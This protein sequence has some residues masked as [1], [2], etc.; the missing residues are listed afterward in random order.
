QEVTAP[1]K[2]HSQWKD[3]LP[4][5][6][7]IRT[8]AGTPV[9]LAD[10]EKFLLSIFFPN[11]AILPAYS[12]YLMSTLISVYVFLFLFAG[13]IGLAIANSITWPSE[14]LAAK[15]RSVPL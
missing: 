2:G 5:V 4:F 15:L 7:R 10:N 9:F 6:N 13:S 3:G 8:D 11:P 1:F 12:H 14:I